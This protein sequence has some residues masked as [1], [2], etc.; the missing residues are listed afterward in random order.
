MSVTISADLSGLDRMLDFL[1]DEIKEVVR[2]AAQA[3]AQVLYDEVKRGV[4][5]MGKQTGNLDR[6]IYQAYSR[7]NSGQGRATYHVSWNAR[8]APH[9]HLVEYGHIQRFRVFMG[10]DGKWVTDKAHLLPQPRQVAAR[11]F[12]R[13]AMAKFDAAAAAAESVILKRLGML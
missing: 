2:P 1:G 3:G 5:R 4:A 11:P 13:P 8:K 10:K 12:V 7:D 6:A 9:G